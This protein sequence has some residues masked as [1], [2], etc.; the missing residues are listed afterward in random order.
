MIDLIINNQL[1]SV[2]TFTINANPK[3][4]VTLANLYISTGVHLYIS[5]NGSSTH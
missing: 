5:N 4:I 1:E 2:K 3:L